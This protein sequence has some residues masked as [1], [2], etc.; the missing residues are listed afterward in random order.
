MLVY[1]NAYSL[2]NSCMV[3]AEHSKHVQLKKIKSQ[4]LMLANS[5]TRQ[6]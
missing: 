3:H 6:A 2:V 1:H 5:K 4:L